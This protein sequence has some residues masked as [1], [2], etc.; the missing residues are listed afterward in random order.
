MIEADTR[1]HLA[2]GRLFSS[3]MTIGSVAG[4]IVSADT[5]ACVVL[6]INAMV[7]L[8]LSLSFGTELDK[9]GIKDKTR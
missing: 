5:V 8:G 7:W 3:F 4:M 9:L 1:R 6:G 2:R